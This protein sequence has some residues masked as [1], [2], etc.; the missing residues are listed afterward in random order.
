MIKHQKKLL[1][2]LIEF[3]LLAVALIGYAAGNE[4]NISPQ[5][6]NITEGIHSDPH[7]VSVMFMN[8]GRAD[9]TLIQIDGLFYLIDTG[10]KS[11]VPQLYGALAMY[12]VERL[13]AVFLTH[14]HSDHIGG[15]KA[16]AQEY[17]IGTLYSSE[18]SKDKKNGENKIDTLA[19]K[20]SLKHVKLSAGDSVAVSADIYFEVLGPLVYNTDDNDN[21]LV[22]RLSVN[23]TII[24]F[25]GDM[26]FAEEASLLAAGID[27][28]ADILKVGNHGNPDATSADFVSAI[29]PKVAII[30][31]N[32]LEDSNSANIRVISLLKGAR[33]LL[34]ENFTLGILL[35]VGVN[36]DVDISDPQPQKQNADIDI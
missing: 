2:I 17:E 29:T 23:G 3:V 4:Q 24:L 21:S 30:S 18:I 36:G 15:L 26:Q 8:V 34:T 31:T 13:E 11:S 5:S 14:T 32:T 16:I 28:H 22:L 27:L 25:C 33:V 7:N 19:S 12:G 35:K 20:L 10:S 6:D 1:S 9:A